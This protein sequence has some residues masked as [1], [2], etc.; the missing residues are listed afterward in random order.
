MKIGKTLGVMFLS[1]Y[2]SSCFRSEHKKEQL[3]DYY[4][5]YQPIKISA[6]REEIKESLQ[7]QSDLEKKIK[8]YEKVFRQ[9]LKYKIT[10]KK[11]FD[12]DESYE[13]YFL[14]A[15]NQIEPS[16]ISL[17]VIDANCNNK[18]CDFALVMN[19]K[20][21]NNNFRYLVLPSSLENGILKI[22]NLNIVY[23]KEFSKLKKK[24]YLAKVLL[25]S[26]LS[27][28]NQN[29]KEKLIRK[30]KDITK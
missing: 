11:V 5:E 20:D 21:F 22:K 27:E 17:D 16:S 18:N 3:G 12:V 14:Y 7:K 23:N 13:A 6:L 19:Y 24:E 9:P 1:L 25:V 2:L 28:K 8:S 26:I 4:F 10:L 15:I 29:V 30:L